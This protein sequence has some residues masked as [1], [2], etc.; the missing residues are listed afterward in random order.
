MVSSKLP[1]CYEDTVGNA[2][3]S[4][5]REVVD[6]VLEILRQPDAATTENEN[7]PKVYRI[8]AWEGTNGWAYCLNCG[9]RDELYQPLYKD[10]FL[11]GKMIRCVRCGAVIRGEMIAGLIDDDLFSCLECMNPMADEPLT[12]KDF[13][14]GEKV[15]CHR[16]GKIIRG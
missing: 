3:A 15:D 14:P 16:C 2:I 7:S 10:D 6:R 13:L 1:V 9:D 8:I 12:E 11:F 5:K 4:T